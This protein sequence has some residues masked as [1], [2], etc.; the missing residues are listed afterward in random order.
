MSNLSCT[1]IVYVT[2]FSSIFFKQVTGSPQLSTIARTLTS[3]RMLVMTVTPFPEN[4]ER[5]GFPWQIYQLATH[6]GI[7]TKKTFT[8][9]LL[10][11]TYKVSC[12]WKTGQKT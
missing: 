4:E 2:R 10:L 12:F 1:A 9:F 3:R 11:E 8:L 5:V 7:V 6:K